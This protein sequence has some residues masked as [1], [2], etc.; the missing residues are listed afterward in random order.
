MPPGSPCA[1]SYQTDAPE[2]AGADARRAP[3]PP[4]VW[5]MVRSV[6]PVLGDMEDADRE[7]KRAVGFKR[8]FLLPAVVLTL[9]EV[10]VVV[11]PFFVLFDAGEDASSRLIRIAVPVLGGAV[12]IWWA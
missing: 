8:H 1:R 9:A 3:G 10:L 7:G 2:P 5:C 11:L 4:E 6:G 12:L